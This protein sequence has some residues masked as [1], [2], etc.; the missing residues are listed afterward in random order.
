M[1][2]D[3]KERRFEIKIL[4]G[5]PLIGNTHYQPG[6][7]LEIDDPRASEMV[8]EGLAEIVQETTPVDPTPPAIE[9]IPPPPAPVVVAP[10]EPGPEAAA[11]PEATPKAPPLAPAKVK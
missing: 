3:H 7:T 2:R 9:V 11:S 6:D 10:A 8:A 5:T 4:K 1:T